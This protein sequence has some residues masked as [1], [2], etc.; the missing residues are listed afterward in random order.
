MD[1]VFNQFDDCYFTKITDFKYQD[2]NLIIF[3][4]RTKN[5]NRMQT[6]FC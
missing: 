3:L 5:N 1:E 6:N 4:A 2:N